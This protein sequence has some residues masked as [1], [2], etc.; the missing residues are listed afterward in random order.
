MMALYRPVMTN[1]WVCDDKFQDY[2]LEGKLLFL[3]LIT[4]D[5]LAESGIYK[6]TFK[7]IA[8][9][10]DISKDK[11]E[12]LIRGELSNNVSYDEENKVIFVHKFFK[13][14]KLGSPKNI[15]TSIDKGMGLIKTSLWEDFTKTYA[16]VLD[17]LDKASRGDGKDSNR[18]RNRNSNDSSINK[19]KVLR[20][21]IVNYLNEKTGKRFV[22]DS[23]E[24]IEF[25][26]GR[27]ED[28]GN[29]AKWEDF[30]HVI[31]IKVND[32][33]G[34][35]KY[36]QYLRP[37]TLFRPS[38]FESYRNQR[39]ISQ[40]DQVGYSPEKPKTPEQEEREAFFSKKK[41][42]II[43]KYQ[44]QL[45]KAKTLE[46]KAQVENLINTAFGKFTQKEGRL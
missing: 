37:S 35:S 32:W 8:N 23:K 10:T 42:E 11:V 45:D 3:Y 19:N 17:D 31:D 16:S 12:E 24:A 6:I 22:A 43:A 26:N 41:S 14:N 29:P 38:N 13:F 1:L 7:T 18:N 34:D 15:L 5:H 30:K 27:I 20:H 36:D 25:I 46:E 21:K 28:K 39:Y 33:L 2:S 4:N 40:G 44:K 9:E